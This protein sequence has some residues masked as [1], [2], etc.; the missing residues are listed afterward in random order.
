[1]SPT[2]GE[3]IGLGYVEATHAEP[4]ADVAVVVRGDQ[5]AAVVTAPPF[6]GR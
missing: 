2:L 6:L 5:K 4:G 1:M 3:P